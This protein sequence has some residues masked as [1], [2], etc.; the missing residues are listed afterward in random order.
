MPGVWRMCGDRFLR[1]ISSLAW[2]L[3]ETAWS[4]INSTIGRRAWSHKKAGQPCGSLW[5]R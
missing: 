3:V 5:H 4:S 1:D 2:T